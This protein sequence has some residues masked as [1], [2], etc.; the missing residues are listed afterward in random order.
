MIVF[1]NTTTGLC[2]STANGITANLVIT[3]G[4][5]FYN[6]ELVRDD[7]TNVSYADVPDQDINTY[8]ANMMSTPKL[9]S[10]LKQGVPDEVRLAA[11]EQAILAQLTGSTA[12]TATTTTTTTAAQSTTGATTT[13]TAASPA[14]NFALIG[15]V[16]GSITATDLT[17]L[18]STGAITDVES[19]T[20]QGCTLQN[21]QESL[22]V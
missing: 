22:N 12:Q 5:A 1:Y 9:F 8:D 14:Y 3:N 19:T 15:F 10:A 17:N 2:I 13:T 16:T 20:I 11:I 7:M 6:S 18:L 21:W 4:Q